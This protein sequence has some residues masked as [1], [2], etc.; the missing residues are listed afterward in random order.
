[1]KNDYD[2]IMLARGALGRPFIFKQI[3]EMLKLNT[4]LNDEK[5]QKPTF[6]EL[7]IKKKIEQIESKYNDINLIKET[8]IKHLLLL[9]KTK[10][11]KIAVKEIRKFVGYYFVNVPNIKKFKNKINQIDTLK[12]IESEVS[13]I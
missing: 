3:E 10:G 4:K 13:K 8:F 1:M 9:S 11:E 7:K 12:E 2:G 6:D 5:K